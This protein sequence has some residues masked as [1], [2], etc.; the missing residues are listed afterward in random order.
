MWRA[1][2]A[3]LA[4]VTRSIMGSAPPSGSLSSDVV[5]TRDHSDVTELER[6]LQEAA[7]DRELTSLNDELSSTKLAPLEEIH[8]RDTTRRASVEVERG[9]HEEIY[10]SG[11]LRELVGEARPLDLEHIGVPLDSSEMA[12]HQDKHLGEERSLGSDEVERPHGREITRT[13]ELTAAL[14]EECCDDMKRGASRPSSVKSVKVHGLDAMKSGVRIPIATAEHSMSRSRPLLSRSRVREGTLDPRETPQRR[15][16]ELPQSMTHRDRVSA[17]EQSRSELTSSGEEPS[18]LMT[19]SDPTAWGGG[20]GLHAHLDS[21]NSSPKRR[22]SKGRR[23]KSRH[24]RD[25][26]ED[27]KVLNSEPNQNLADFARDRYIDYDEVLTAH[28]KETPKRD[29]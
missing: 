25:T 5:L 7:D 22:S 29:D 20:A 15:S 13:T 17:Q 19:L 11:D 14:Y 2:I 12:L 28:I 21:S 10:S 8:I 26:R 18:A 23:P 27:L 6:L 24:G 4:R 1:L 3:T 9:G 16:V